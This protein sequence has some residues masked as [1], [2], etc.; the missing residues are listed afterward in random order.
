MHTLILVL[1]CIK[2]YDVRS[3]KLLLYLVFSHINSLFVLWSVRYIFKS[4]IA[5]DLYFNLKYFQLAE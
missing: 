1:Q 4:C 2:P 3:S 5:H